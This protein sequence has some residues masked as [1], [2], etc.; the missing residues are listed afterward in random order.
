VVAVEA[1]AAVEVVARVK[2]VALVGQ[3]Q[4]AIHLV[5]ADPML[6]QAGNN[7]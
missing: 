2:A 4:Q 7:C 1:R 5:V 6:L 3:A